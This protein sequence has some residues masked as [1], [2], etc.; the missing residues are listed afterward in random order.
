MNVYQRNV[1]HSQGRRRFQGQSNKLSEPLIKRWKTKREKELIEALVSRLPS[2]PQIFQRG[3]VF[4]EN[5]ST[6]R[7]PPPARRDRNEHTSALKFEPGDPD[8]IATRQRSETWLFNYNS[9]GVAN[10]SEFYRANVID[11]YRGAWEKSECARARRTQEKRSVASNRSIN[12]RPL[13]NGRFFYARKILIVSNGGLDFP[14][15]K[16]LD[17]SG[18]SAIFINSSLF[19]RAWFIWSRVAGLEWTR[20]WI[21]G[22]S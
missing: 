22:V 16:W 3:L 4:S 5:S 19:F 21:Y 2:F 14:F 12:N 18:V 10:G 1:Q 13:N 9:S 11:K 7:R 20:G 17:F 15:D 8:P 6:S